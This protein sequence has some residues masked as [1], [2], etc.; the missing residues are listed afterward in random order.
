MQTATLGWEFIAA[1]LVLNGGLVTILLF[2][3]GKTNTTLE[4]LLDKIDQKVSFTTCTEY[5]ETCFRTCPTR[6]HVERTN[7]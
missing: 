6:Q 3:M 7:G 5:R 4:K 1:L 2:I